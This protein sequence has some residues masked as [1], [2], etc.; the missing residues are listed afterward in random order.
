M[1]KNSLLTKETAE[2]FLKDND[3][4]D[5][6]TFTD[7]EDAAAEILTGHKGSL[8]LNALKNL[9]ETAASFLARVEPI[10]NEFNSLQLGYAL[11]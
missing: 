3:S 11:I 1:I 8:C 2:K 5:L 9:S 7:I 10:K 6:R 4:V